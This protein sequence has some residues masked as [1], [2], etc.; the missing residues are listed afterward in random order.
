MPT[1]R[2]FA[3]G[4]SKHWTTERFDNLDAHRS[5]L[6]RARPNLAWTSNQ[7]SPGRVHGSVVSC[8]SGAMAVSCT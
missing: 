5:A 8:R 7:L 6:K 1:P 3:G 2:D 4:D